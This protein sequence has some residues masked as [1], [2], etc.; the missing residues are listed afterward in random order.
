MRRFEPKAAVRDIRA[1]IDHPI[2][3]ADGHQIEFMPLVIDEVGKLL[4]SSGANDFVKFISSVADPDTDTH[5]RSRVFWGLPEENTL[6]RMTSTLPRLLY[7]RL[8]ALGLDYVLLYPTI[9]LTM[10]GCA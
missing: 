3:D 5:S 4:G 9:G 2:V 7:Q 8:D 10:L 6:D 1:E